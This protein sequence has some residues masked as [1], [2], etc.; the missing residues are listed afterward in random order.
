MNELARVTLQNEMDLILAH[1][2]S[3]K[4][5]ELAGL[6]L[7]AQTTFATAV[8]EVSRTAI[9]NGR[10][11]CLILSV[12]AEGRVKYIVATLKDERSGSDKSKEG[13]EYAKRLVSKY[14][15]SA[16]GNE[17]SVELFYAVSTQMRMDLPQLDEWRSLFRN[18]PPVSAYDELKRKNEQLQELSEKVLKSETQ[19]RTLTNSLPMIIFSVDE[20]GDILYANE[21]LTQLTGESIDQLN[22][23]AWKTSVHIDDYDAFLLLLNNV[24][25]KNAATVKLQ[26]RMRK[27]GGD[28]L[29]HQVSLSPLHNEKG[30]LQYRIGYIVDIHAQ[31]VLEE[32]LL[33]NIEL[34]E[35][36]KK[37]EENKQ[38]LE[39]Y[40]GELARSNHELQQFAFVASHD[41]QEPVR[42]ILFYSD[43]L[44]GRYKEAIDKKSGDY[45]SFIQA[46]GKR[47]RSLIQDLLSYSQINKEELV[48]N[49]VDLNITAAHAVH[50]FSLAVEQKGA[51]VNIEPL[52]VVKG[53]ERMLRQLFENI[54]S[55]ALKYSLLGT[56]PVINIGC[57]EQNG[58][59]ELKFTDNGIGFDNQ[60]AV[61]IFSLFQRLHNKNSFEGT[62]L[63]LAI[64][65]KIAE[66]H[67]GSI[68]AE[69]VE[70]AGATFF[71]SLPI[72][73]SAP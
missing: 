24:N 1:R 18:E 47:M 11:G 33:D 51:T 43:Y 68:W 54:L 2:R 4:L 17:T 29:W 46:A 56:K 52:P 50:D 42:K 44:V 55:N 9:E 23:S 61:Q 14:N 26:V 62:G 59:Y 48:F 57:S 15:V 25:L 45:L 67:G 20:E 10:S 12:E 66:L 6:S 39:Q 58:F 41:L 72:I 32:T 7:S 31:K 8:S 70:N 53:D 34:K 21:W 35:A 37:L 16:E 19:Y 69:G 22:K 73:Q 27:K 65:R 40:I 13:L 36:Q 28:Y 38:T 60:Y 5:A 64:C 3:M 49:D 63:G 71:V 30:E